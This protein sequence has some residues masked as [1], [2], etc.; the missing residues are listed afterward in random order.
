LVSASLDGM[1][2]LWDFPNHTFKKELVGH[3]KGV[4]SLDWNN[5]YKYLVSAGLD[6][7]AFV[8]NTYV[9][10]KISLLRGHN[11]PL[12]GVKCLKGTNQ[13]VTADISGMVKVWDVRNFLCMQT[14]NVPV[15]ELNAFTLTFPKKRI[16]TGARNLLFYDYDEPKDQLLTDEKVCMKVIYNDIL[17]SFIT[18]HPDSVKIWDARNGKLV[19]VHREL[20]G[21]DLTSC[22]L[23]SR[24]RKLFVADAEG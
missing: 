22:C 12:V 23:D 24:E 5:E 9:S 1:I 20:S 21:A 2:C 4:Y 13:I 16:V 15:E 14:F 3:E 7:E 17:L 8:W 19:S 18:L 11:H 10:E 6:H